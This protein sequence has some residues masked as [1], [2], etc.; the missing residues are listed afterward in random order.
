MPDSPPSIGVHEQYPMTSSKICWEMN[1]Y[2]LLPLTSLQLLNM[3]CFFFLRFSIYL[4]YAPTHTLQ[5]LF[6]SLDNKS[7]VTVPWTFSVIHRYWRVEGHKLLLA[8]QL[9]VLR[10]SQKQKST[11]LATSVRWIKMVR[12][13]LGKQFAT[14]D[15]HHLLSPYEREC[16]IP[17]GQGNRLQSNVIS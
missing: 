6:F 5:L 9:Q 4:T 3:G 1:E 2:L 11:E 13:T 15:K 17:V 12:W 14:T 7:Y 10:E 16:P 8:L